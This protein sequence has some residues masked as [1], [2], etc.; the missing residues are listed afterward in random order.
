MMSRRVC[1]SSRYSRVQ[2]IYMDPRLLDPNLNMANVYQSS[3]GITERKEKPDTTII[4]A[5]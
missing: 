5:D 1:T 4:R 3:V 2:D